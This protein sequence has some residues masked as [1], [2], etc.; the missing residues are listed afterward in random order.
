MTAAQAT[1]TTRS[2]PRL[3]LF[4]GL[5][6]VGAGFMLVSW[7][8]PWWGARVSDLIVPG[9]HIAMRPWGV[10]LI[11]SVA[12]YIDKSLYA[13]PAFFAP[14]MWMYLGL[15]MVALA[16]SLFVE[17]KFT[18]GRFKLSLPQV[19]IGIVGLTYLIAAVAAFAIAQLKS[20]DAGVHFLG[21]TVVYNPALGEPSTITAGLESGY[22]LTVAA[23]TL[24]VVLALLRNVIIGKARP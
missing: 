14:L 17:K 6:L 20:G 7:L 3:W 23:G 16:A 18:L 13:M 1:E 22:W 11:N 8:T 24:L 2:I 15:C 21:S 9:N 10:E 4:R 12:P 19:L 5:L